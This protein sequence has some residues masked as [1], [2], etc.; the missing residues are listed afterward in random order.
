MNSERSRDVSQKYRCRQRASIRCFL[1]MQRTYTLYRLL[2][3]A[4]I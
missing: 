3:K 1:D 4:C 2:L